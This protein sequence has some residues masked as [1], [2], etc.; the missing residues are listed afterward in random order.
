LVFERGLTITGVAY[1][2]AI[3]AI[4]AAGR[5]FATFLRRYDVILPATLPAPPLSLAISICTAMWK[6]L[7]SV[8]PSIYQFTPLHDAVGLLHR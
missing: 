4:R 8:R 5:K 2:D 3:A 1:V 7:T 6:L